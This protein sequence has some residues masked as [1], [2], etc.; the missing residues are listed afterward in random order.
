MREIYGIEERKIHNML[1]DSAKYV[2][3]CLLGGLAAGLVAV[4]MVALYCRMAGP[5]M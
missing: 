1:W 4:G 5:L 2:G 3:A